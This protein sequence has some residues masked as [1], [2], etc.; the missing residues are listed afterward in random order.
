M[1]TPLRTAAA[2]VLAATLGL[3]PSPASAAEPVITAKP[4]S[5]AGKSAKSVTLVTGD[6]VTLSQDRE[7]RTVGAVSRGPGREKIRF[8]ARTVEGHLRVVP[9]DAA[10]LLA[11]G[12][13]DPRLFDVT[14]LADAGF[15]DRATNEIPLIVT[16]NPTSLAR[17]SGSR[18]THNLGSIGAVALEQPKAEA[19]SLWQRLA[20]AGKGTKVWLNGRNEV[21]DEGSNAQIGVPAAR[22]AGYDGTGVSVAV[23]DTGIDANHPDLL[24]VLGESVD[25]TGSPDGVKDTV[26]HGTHVAS[27]IAGT[28]TVTAANAG[29]APKAKVL[30]GK[31][32]QTRFCEDADIIAG[33]Q[34]AAGKAKI[35]NLSLG[36][37]FGTDGTDPLSQAVNNLTEETGTLFVAAAGNSARPGTVGGPAAANA[38]LAVGSVGRTD[39]VSGFSSKGPRVGD[40]AV[41]PDIAAPGE[42]IVAGRAEGTGMGTPAGPYYT[43]ASGT[44]MAAPHV[45]G[46]AALLA[47][48]HPAW[49]AAQLKAALM[50]TSAPVGGQ[51]VFNVGAGR[52]D[53]GRAVTQQVYADGS[54]SFARLTWPHSAS[55]P[56]TKN[57]TYTNAGSAPVTLDL[58]I[59]GSDAFETASATLTVPAGGTATAPVTLTPAKVPSTGGS[60]S[61][62]LAASAAGVSVQTALGVSAE[63][64]SFTM[65]V[66]LTDRAG[67]PADGELEQEVFIN[68]LTPGGTN[69]SPRVVDGVATV[70][71]PKG[72]YHVHAFTATAAD[73]GASLTF[74]VQSRV[75]LDAD[76]SLTFDARRGA[77]S[78]ITVADRPEATQDK[79][80]LFYVLRIGNS[81]GTGFTTL[82]AGDELYA[83]PTTV[84]EG[85]GLEFG[86]FSE[87]QSPPGAA[88]PYRYYATGALPSN[89]IPADPSWRVRTRDQARFN[90]AFQ[91]QGVP[92][93]SRFARLAYFLPGQSAA[94]APYSEVSMPSSRT[95]YLSAQGDWTG[96]MNFQRP[97]GQ[98][99]AG[100][101]GF[102]LSMTG[103]P[104]AGKTVAEYW[105]R[106]AVGPSLALAPNHGSGIFRSDGDLTV[107]I[108]MFSPAQAGT[109]N[110]AP[111]QFITATGDTSLQL[112]GYDPVSSGTPGIASFGGL[113]PES[114]RYVLKASAT[115]TDWIPWST[116]ST[117][118]E[119]SWTFRSS[120][121]DGVLPLMY[122]R[123][124]GP[125][126][127]L[128]RARRGLFPI[129]VDVLRQPWSTTTAKVTGVGV[130]YSADDGVT[131]KRAPV[132]KAGG[133]WLAVVLN[134]AGGFVSLRTTTA[135]SVGDQHTATVIRA[136]SVK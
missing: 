98:P 2:V 46:A 33:M 57:V 76:K 23:L 52:V 94:F 116:L 3:L 11:A 37:N 38:A 136:Y 12:R 22:A 25:F 29:V 15:D 87:L 114:A 26:G 121:G 124:T 54:L 64:E 47:Q 92:A 39:Q 27:I 89:T 36:S 70:R 51:S 40:D 83:V 75:A 101:F 79:H 120:E 80:T 5:E 4:V 91:A 100:P 97:A 118:T 109:G 119:A 44:S 132:I 68:A 134:P 67:K 17:G 41:K 131:W 55:E 43:A 86:L 90:V 111:F 82:T 103:K 105:N 135:D 110:F 122:A 72:D 58:T 7:G 31:V 1:R 113:P 62:R 88:R 66:S 69:A 84:A 85:T 50:S 96:A 30:V 28:G 102:A 95:D 108:P 78:A 130:E 104:Q 74:E 48:A 8:S 133:S 65:R 128:N 71:L 10:P 24:S 115:R 117:K 20:A 106:A 127:E 53:V 81:R 56:V 32:C 13:L 9:S 6:R 60:L 129:T 61:A 63:P 73:A 125:F 49:T 19:T 16:G 59:T 42:D 99:V 126:D 21:V 112:E 77:K 45:A 34:W 18:V 123:T 14:A 107:G 35:V 93:D